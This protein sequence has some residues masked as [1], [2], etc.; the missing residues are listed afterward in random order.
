[1]DLIFAGKDELHAFMDR[2]QDA[3]YSLVF[4]LNIRP[5]GTPSD[6][7][8]LLE[9]RILVHLVQTEGHILCIIMGMYVPE[10]P[11]PNLRGGNAA[12][13]FF[14]RCLLK[15]FRWSFQGPVPK[16]S[17]FMVI[18]APHTSNWDAV[19]GLTAILALG[20][21]VSFLGKDSIFVGPLGVLLRAM[22]GIPV[23][24]F[25]SN[26]IVDQ[27]ADLYKE[28]ASFALAM[29]PE[30]T[31]KRGKTWRT[32]FYH[33]ARQAG[34]PVLCAALDYK[35]RQIVFS[36]PMPTSE[37]MHKDFAAYEAFFSQAQA[38]YPKDYTPASFRQK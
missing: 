7:A 17:K 9:I 2:V 35:K 14:G 12:L 34:V 22:G 38:R 30:G 25:S 23:D 29:A 36:E 8:K 3:P 31:R 20:F 32:G 28:R 16:E 19:Y 21:K 11:D 1:M 18:A 24:R 37:D 4:I 27:M 6:S 33:I 5:A 26:K 15:V 10:I 13:R